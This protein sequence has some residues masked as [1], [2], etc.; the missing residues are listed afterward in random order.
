[1]GKGRKKEVKGVLIFLRW[2]GEREKERR[3]R[4]ARK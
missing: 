2:W 1:M 3:K 4:G